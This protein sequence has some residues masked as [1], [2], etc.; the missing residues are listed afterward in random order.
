MILRPLRDR[1]VVLPLETDDISPGGIVIPET[2]KEKPTR[3]KVVAVGNGK[4]L[5]DGK[6]Q[7]MD[8]MVGDHVLYS[9]YGGTTIELGGEEYVIL[10]ESDLLAVIADEAE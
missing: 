6:R 4:R 9:K 3:G 10:A 8:V 2:A 1:V 7:G 5:E